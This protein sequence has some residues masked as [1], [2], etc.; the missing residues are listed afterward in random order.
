MSQ[1][2]RTSLNRTWLIKMAVFFAFL[3]GL[4]TWGYYDATVK[5]PARG[6]RH[7]E[8]AKWQYLGIAVNIGQASRAGVKDPVEEFARLSE[9][10]NSH[11][12]MR[13]ACPQ[14]AGTIRTGSNSP[15]IAG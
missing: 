2:T 8:W 9:H 1:V 15:V 6:V 14:R 7:A 10:S 4:G 3:A 13:P 12:S 5:W 11:K